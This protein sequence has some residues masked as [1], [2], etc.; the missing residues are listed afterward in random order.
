M[1][2]HFTYDDIIFRIGYFRTK[3]NLSA[4][5]LSLRVGYSES[6][7]NRIER[8]LVDLKVQ[9]LI[10]IM[11]YFEITPEEFFYSKPEEYEKDKEIFERISELSPD[12][13]ARLLDLAKHM[14]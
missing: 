4:R 3:H 1:N 6:Y 7:I 5:E 2:K 13:K 9:N 10:E 12:N 11:D 8:K 14:K